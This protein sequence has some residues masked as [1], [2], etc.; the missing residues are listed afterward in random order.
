MVL[1]K[2]KGFAAWRFGETVMLRLVL[3]DEDGR[4]ALPGLEG[5]VSPRLEKMRSFDI[6]SHGI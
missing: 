5:E 2:T 4:M 3:V 1:L 6:Y